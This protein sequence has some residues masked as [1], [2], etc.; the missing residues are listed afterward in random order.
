MSVTHILF[1]DVDSSVSRPVNFGL[2][3]LRHVAV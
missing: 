1:L 3:L 2:L